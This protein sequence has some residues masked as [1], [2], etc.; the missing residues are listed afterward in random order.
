M[1]AWSPATSKSTRRPPA[2]SWRQ[3]SWGRCSTTAATPSGTWSTSSS[4]R[5]R[6]FR[7]RSYK[8]FFG[9]SWS[10]A[11]VLTNK[12]SHV[13]CLR[14]SDMSNNQRSVNW[15]RKIFI[16]TG[17]DPIE[18]LSASI[19]SLLEVNIVIGQF[20]SNETLFC[21]SEWLISAQSNI[22]RQNVCKDSIYGPRWRFHPGL[23]TCLNKKLTW[24]SYCACHLRHGWTN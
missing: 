1:S 20:K 22:L 11:E 21:L 24:E 5:Y 7:T 18:I 23:K 6:E 2:S 12:S 16:G 13:T 9:V 15:S 19:Y 4:M 10:Y 14:L 8:T 3:R 17:P